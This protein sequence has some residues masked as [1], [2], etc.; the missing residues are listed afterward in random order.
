M[1]KINE[2]Y[3]KNLAIYNQMCETANSLFQKMNVRDQKEY[4]ASEIAKNL[5]SSI[6]LPDNFDVQEKIVLSVGDFECKLTYSSLFDRLSMFEKLIK[7]SDK[8]K[9]AKTIANLNPVASFVVPDNIKKFVALAKKV[10][11]MRPIMQNIYFDVKAS[12]IVA[13]DGRLLLCKQVESNLWNIDKL[14]D[15]YP[16]PI[17]VFTDCEKISIQEDSFGK[18]YAYNGALTAEIPDGRYPM[19]RSVLSKYAKDQKIT[20]GKDFLKSVKMVTKIYGREDDFY[21]KISSN[22][23]GDM[24]ILAATDGKQSKQTITANYRNDFEV[25]LNAKY[26]QNMLPFKEFYVQESGRAVTFFDDGCFSLLMPV[27]TVEKSP[28]Y[29]V[30]KEKNTEVEKFGTLSLANIQEKDPNDFVKEKKNLPAVVPVALPVAVVEEK[31]Q[32][33]VEESVAVEIAEEIQAVVEDI[34]E[35][36]EIAEEIP[37]VTKKRRSKEELASEEKF[38]IVTNQNGD[39]MRARLLKI[40][41]K[42][43]TANCLFKGHNRFSVPISQISDT[44]DQTSGFTLPEWLVKGSKITSDGIS[45]VI[46]EKVLRSS[47]SCVESPEIKLRDVILFYRPFVEKVEEKK[48]EKKNGFFHRLLRKVACF[49]F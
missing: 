46:V 8:K 10:N 4:T 26:L 7:A 28:L 21:V 32:P 18:T 41:E 25:C 20:V 22:L 36:V 2:Q 33:I 27:S 12:A 35:H 3:E 39:K 15:G 1:S 29:S 11:Q 5:Y 42:K 13:A 16:I 44:E 24:V 40:S 34:P 9:F 48:E 19:W 30:M 37:V 43:G 47:V 14:K 49:S 31:S 38:V 45:S 17:E 6:F 23:E